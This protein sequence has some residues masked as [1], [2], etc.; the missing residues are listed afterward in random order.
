M[1]SLLL[2]IIYLTFISLGLPDALLGSAWPVMHADLGA[3]V[4]AQSVISV[5]ISCCTIVSSLLT[6]RLVRRLGTGRLCALS[7]A[8]T[9]LAIL[10]FSCTGQFWQLCLIAI[11]YGLGAGAIDSALNNYVALNFGARHMSWLH[12]CWGIG[13]SA[14]PVVMGWALAGPM[15]WHGGYLA[16]GAIQAVI[17]AVLFFSLP[18]WKQTDGSARARQGAV[19]DENAQR[20]A[21]L[22]NRELLQI[23]G[24]K[25]AIGSFGCYCALEGATGLWMA[26]YLVMSR[27]VEAATAASIVSLFY[28]GITV[29]RLAS[30]MIASALGSAQQIRI[31]Q[32]LIGA[33][34]TLLLIAPVEQLIWVAIGLIG[35]GCAPIYP[36]IVALTPQRF[37]A[38]ASQGMVSLQM[39]C[40]YTGSSLVPPVFGLVA[41]AGGAWAI[42]WLL[43]VFLAANALLCEM[44]T[45]DTA[46]RNAAGCAEKARKGSS[47]DSCSN[48]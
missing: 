14:G 18:L 28:L 45:K 26:S 48:D 27:G 30:G 37:G 19:N 36:S 25:A 5:I 3:P 2:A 10:G 16:I 44:A 47:H 13:A 39:A 24:A 21:P 20:D 6:A 46:G 17:T 29:G 33:G 15:S 8:L 43:A 4:A 32:C 23:P 34:L 12:C 42:P 7:V 11:P 41:G 38:R 31:G 9:A 40:A 1:V 22:T 35:L